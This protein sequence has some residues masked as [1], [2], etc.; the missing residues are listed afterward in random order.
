MLTAFSLKARPICAKP[1]C[2]EKKKFTVTVNIHS[3]AGTGTET[4]VGTPALYLS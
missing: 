2:S 4:A 3:A 1:P